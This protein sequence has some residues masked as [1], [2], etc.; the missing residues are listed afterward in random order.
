ML[1]KNTMY[2]VHLAD[3]VCIRIHPFDKMVS[4]INLNFAAKKQIGNIIV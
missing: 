4:K 2:I 3:L 1:C